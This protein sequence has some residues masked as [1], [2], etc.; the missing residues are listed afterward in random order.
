MMLK[1][2]YGVT[3]MERK[4][5]ETFKKNWVQYVKIDKVWNLTRTQSGNSQKL[6]VRT[7]RYG[8]RKRQRK[9]YSRWHEEGEIGKKHEQDQSCEGMAF[10]T[11]IQCMRV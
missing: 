4:A 5:S 8:I 11:P 7:Q 3:V 2:V 6:D 10:W 9:K 1:W